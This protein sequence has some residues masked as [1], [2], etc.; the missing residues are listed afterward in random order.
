MTRIDS[1]HT[2]LIAPD[3]AGILATFFEENDRPEI[4]EQFHPFA[5]TRESARRIAQHAEGD[6]HYLCYERHRPVGFWML[7][8]WSQGH[9]VPAFGLFVDCREQGKGVGRWMLHAA[10]AECRVL[11]CARMLVT[12]YA[13]NLASIAMH[14]AIGFREVSRTPLRIAGRHRIKLRLELDLDAVRVD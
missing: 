6:R 14:T 11:G 13:D 2:R 7:R 1:L 8:G 3:D 10:V 5:L 12:V 9:V 4:V